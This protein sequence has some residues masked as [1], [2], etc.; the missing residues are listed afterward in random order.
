MRDAGTTAEW[1]LVDGSADP[2]SASPAVLHDDH[3]PA[4]ADE[5]SANFFFMGGGGRL[6]VDLGEAI[7]FIEIN[8]YSWHTGER[9]PQVY[10]LYGAT[11]EGEAFL[12]FP[13]SGT[14]VT[15]VG[16]TELAKVDTRTR[17]QDDGGQHVA[18]VT[19]KSDEGGTIGPFRYLLFEIKPTHSR[20]SFG[21]TF[22]SEIDLVA[23]ATTP[24][25]RLDSSARIVEQGV[26]TDGLHRFVVDASAAPDL[27]AWSHSTLLPLVAE[28][29][30]K[31]VALLPSENFVAPD[32]VILEFREGMKAAI[33]AFASANRISLNAGWF[34]NQLEGE[35]SG[36]V[37]HELVHVVQQYGRARLTNP[38]ATTTPGWITE[39]IADYV[40][41]F[42]YEPQSRGGAISADR[43][44][45]ASHD[46][47]Y[48]VS[49]NF[50]DW[51][52][53]NRDKNLL[54]TLNATV[55][56]GTYHES[57]WQE[58]TGATLAELSPVWRKDLEV[59]SRD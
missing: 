49:A 14:D 26:T 15:K 21:N 39:G 41:W 18:S 13:Q 5:P 29:Y 53:R 51:V 47:S 52:I 38:L 31:I 57:L 56:S 44:A 48:R 1:T 58:W 40:R 45:E 42:L 32:T 36:C 16:W 54:Q 20:N 28:W 8:T 7:R 35:A 30:P 37:V 9:A 25:E 33:P 10:G 4:N 22:F 17:F 34:R 11:G 59:N 43:I 23:S 6:V 3:L 12:E 2:N 27:A 19:T 50:L 24:P 55:R 46:A